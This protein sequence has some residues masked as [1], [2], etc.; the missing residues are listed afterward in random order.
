MQPSWRIMNFFIV[1]Y[2]LKFE[3]L[4]DIDLCDFFHIKKKCNKIYDN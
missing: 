1:K 2:V 3:A 4:S